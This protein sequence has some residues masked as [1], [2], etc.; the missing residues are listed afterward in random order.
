M[1]AAIPTSYDIEGLLKQRGSH[2]DKQRAGEGTKSLHPYASPLGVLSSRASF[3]SEIWTTSS[4]ATGRSPT[5]PDVEYIATPQGPFHGNSF[6]SAESMS[7]SEYSP[8][9]AS[10]RE[11][12]I[13]SPVLDPLV[14][15]SSAVF[16]P[17]LV[18]NREH[19]LAIQMSADVEAFPMPKPR[20]PIVRA[21]E[22]QMP[23]A[24]PARR[25]SSIDSTSSSQSNNSTNDDLPLAGYGKMLPGPAKNQRMQSYLAPKMKLISPPP[26][27]TEE[28]KSNRQ[29]VWSKDEGKMASKGRSVKEAF[30]RASS[31][32][33]AKVRPSLDSVRVAPPQL[34]P[35]DMSSKPTIAMRRKNESQKTPVPMS[36]TTFPPPRGALPPIPTQR[37][38]QQ[39]PEERPSDPLAH[40]VSPA[41]STTTSSMPR[42]SSL[43]S[44]GDLTS[45]TSQSSLASDVTTQD[46][47]SPVS[48][49]KV[50]ARQ[51]APVPNHFNLVSLDA[52]RER[53]KKT[54]F[55]H[56]M[57][58]R[59]KYSTDTNDSY[60]SSS[61]PKQL[62]NKKSGFLKL[63]NR[64]DDQQTQL[65]SAPP[66]PLPPLPSTA[67][68]SA[69]PNLTTFSQAEQSRSIE[70]PLPLPSPSPRLGN[71]SFLAPPQPNPQDRIHKPGSETLP[72]PS[73]SLRPVSMAFSHNFA[74]NLLVNLKEEGKAS[75]PIAPKSPMSAYSGS[76]FFDSR[77]T[78]PSTPLFPPQTPS[79]QDKLSN[80]QQAWKGQL[81]EMEQQIR[82]LENEVDMLRQQRDAN[83]SAKVSSILMLVM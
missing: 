25:H 17:T 46:G 3:D 1:A 11:A 7:G 32:A 77:E 48:A 82:K 76:D 18:S 79:M 2:A 61:A 19:G 12:V 41:S 74:Q 63:F 8:S 9:M 66:M 14:H 55:A 62:K 49:K 43:N 68:R 33:T 64:K 51:E 35:E 73:L 45:S 24:P 10:I 44:T 23:R 34:R 20:A 67:L 21:K 26:W 27:D 72:A 75:S 15:S 13:R 59:R 81:W 5:T 4:V 40:V 57:E 28:E 39:T 31:N 65:V 16:K 69:P 54:P 52:A 37:N 6:S 56:D 30:G 58:E 36:I 42:S 71:V 53:E 78:T 70:R 80:A 47:E 60:A 38:V 22:I 29:D 50:L 83:R